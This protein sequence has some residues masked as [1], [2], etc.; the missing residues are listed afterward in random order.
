MFNYGFVAGSIFCGIALADVLDARGSSLIAQLL[1]SV[2]AQNCWR[3]F[4][5]NTVF[6]S[7]NPDVYVEVMLMRVDLVPKLLEV[8]FLQF[9]KSTRQGQDQFVFENIWHDMLMNGWH[10]VQIQISLAQTHL[11]T[12]RRFFGRHQHVDVFMKIKRGI[13]I[14]A[15]TFGFRN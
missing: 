10:F 5:R 6:G 1:E 4:L 12:T 3:R 11:E 2:L 9:A 7:S 13:T 8:D 15:N 14:P